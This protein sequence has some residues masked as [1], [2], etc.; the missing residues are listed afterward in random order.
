[1]G[2]D[3]RSRAREAQALV[4]M[5]TLLTR[6]V[7]PLF[8]DV[9]GKPWLVGTGL[10]VSGG[11]SSYLVSAAHVLEGPT[12][13]DLYFY[14]SSRMRRRLTG[15]LRTSAP[16]LDVA[17]LLLTGRGLPPYGEIEKASLP[18]TAFSPHATPRHGK[19]YLITG[20][21]SSKNRPNPVAR[22]M[23]S[24]PYALFNGSANP[25]KYD[26]LGIDDHAQFLVKFDRKRSVFP[27]SRVGHSPDPRGM[28]GAPVWLLFDEDGPND[29]AQT[30]VVGIAIEHRRDEHVIVA[31]DIGLAAGLISAPW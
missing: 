20:F 17:V 26:R 21:P 15:H 14:V 16:P 24:K 10:L 13:R 7:V 4:R 12:A 19:H 5:S 29:P 11:G 1:M 18:V 8:I 27:N 25:E 9:R 6:H 28:S 23:T 3:D 30:P 2:V 22:D 31:T